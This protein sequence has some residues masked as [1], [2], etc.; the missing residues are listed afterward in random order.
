VAYLSFDRGWLLD[1]GPTAI[2]D[3]IVRQ[4]GAQ[5]PGHLEMAASVRRQ[6]Q[7]LTQRAKGYGDIASRVSHYTEQFSGDLLRRLGVLTSLVSGSGT[8][9]RL[10]I[11]LDTLEELARRDEAVEQEI[12]YF[13]HDLTAA[14]PWVR[15]VAAGRAVPLQGDMHQLTGLAEPEALALLRTLTSRADRVDRIDQ[16]E[17][18]LREVFELVGGNPLSLR[19]AAD[20]LRRTDEEPARMLAVSEGNVQGQLYSRLLEHIRDPKVRAVAHPGLVVRRITPEIIREVLAGPCGIAPVSVQEAARIF[21]ALRDEATLCVQSR[22]EDHALVHREDVRAI[23]LPAIRRDRPATTR[24]IHQAAAYYYQTH[25]SGHLPIREKLYHLLMLDSDRD[26][27]DRAWNQNVGAQLA[28]VID[29]FPPRAQVYLAT[30]V[31]RLRLDKKTR[32]AADDDQWR[33]VVGTAAR[34]QL[35]NDQ[36][37]AALDLVRER[38]DGR[39][40]PLLPD[41]EVEALERLGRMDEAL[42]LAEAARRQAEGRGDLAL[43]R[44]LITAQ[45]RINER[46]RR[47]V[48]AWNLLANLAA[49]DRARRVRTDAVDDDIRTSELVM[50]TSLLRIAR[51]MGRVADSDPEV[52]ELTEETIRLAR[53]TPRRLLTANTPLLRDLAAEAGEAAPEFVVLADET[54]APETE[55]P[56]TAVPDITILAPEPNTFRTYQIGTDNAQDFVI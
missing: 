45:A 28:T 46:L 16:G 52:A 19:L 4:V 48:S 33:Q 7:Q 44:T 36:P 20:I 53:G 50:L 21:G 32:A 40:R 1:G 56:Q 24:A 25:L 9:R 6:A 12:R 11:V 42:E 18:V 47:W 38:R 31:K 29:E 5:R 26:V 43:V 49:L 22:D 8:D 41:I 15:I 14:I 54:L 2:F 39:G 35:E 51:H 23:M 37:R 3:E 13:L 55:T 17:D 10:V 34:R 30:K 27:L